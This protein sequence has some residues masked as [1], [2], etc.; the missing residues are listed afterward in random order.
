[1]DRILEVYLLVYNC[2]K[3]KIEKEYHNYVQILTNNVEVYVHMQTGW[4]AQF[5]NE[6]GVPMLQMI[7]EVN[8]ITTVEAPEALIVGYNIRRFD[9]QFLYK[10]EKRYDLDSP[11]YQFRSFDVY[12]EFKAVLAGLY[13]TKAKREDWRTAHGMV[14]KNDYSTFIKENKGMGSLNMEACCRYYGVK[15][16]NKKQHHAKYDSILALEVL[17]KQRPEWFE[18]EGQGHKGGTGTSNVPVPKKAVLTT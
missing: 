4:T 8:N 13:D 5:L 14:L 17:K 16:D 12:L 7:A 3:N 11:N 2:K 1:M 6:M 15:V 18:K 9:N 10:Y